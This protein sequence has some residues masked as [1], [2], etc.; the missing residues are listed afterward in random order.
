MP[1]PPKDTPPRYLL[2][3][4]SLQFRSFARKCISPRPSA[5]ERGELSFRRRSSTVLAVVCAGPDGLW[6]TF[7]VNQF[8]HYWCS[9]TRDQ[10]WTSSGLQR[11][12]NTSLYQVLHLS[13][14][15]RVVPSP[16]N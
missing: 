5:N 14:V 11:A 9:G 10:G 4:G 15:A 8:L 2:G 1:R 13:P 7:F 12:G 6:Q 16:S 3:R